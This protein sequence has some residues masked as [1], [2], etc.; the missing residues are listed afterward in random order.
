[1]KIHRSEVLKRCAFSA[2]S[3]STKKEKRS[4]KER[5]RRPVETDAPDGNPKRQDFHSGLKRAFAKNA[6]AFSQFHIGPVVAINLST[7][8][9]NRRPTIGKR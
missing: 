6:P 2:T 7:L 9:K 4:K 3:L 5:N 1:L 8:R